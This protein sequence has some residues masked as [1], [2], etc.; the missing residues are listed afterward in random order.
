MVNRSSALYN[1]ESMNRNK[2]SDRRLLVGL[3][4]LATTAC[5]SASEGERMR[6]DIDNIDVR[7]LDIENSLDEQRE[8]LAQLLDA[9]E[10]EIAQVRIALDEA[11]AILQ[12]ANAGLGV[13]LDAL[14]SEL[15]SL[16]GD[17]ERSDFRVT[18]LQE[19]LSLFIEDV[20][21]RLGNR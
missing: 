10:T 18:Q 2:G 6:G 17:L 3:L 11:Q 8:R 9:A 21:L 13:Q 7:L 20:D 1:T 12:Q 15:Q 4:I 14:S 19:Q 5:V 16:R